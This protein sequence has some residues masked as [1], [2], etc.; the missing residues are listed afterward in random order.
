M[1]STDRPAEPL[2]SGAILA[3]WAEWADSTTFSWRMRGYPPIEVDSY[4][5]AIRDTFLGASQPPVRS[6]SVRGKEFPSTDDPGY[7]KKQVA[8]F[9]EAAGIRLAAIESTDRPAEP[10]VSGA[11]L[12]EWADSTRFSTRRLRE[13]YDKREV[14]VFRSAVRDTFLGAGDPL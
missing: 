14:D 9:L 13:G 5:D 12:A 11:I 3:G 6:A 1:E 7:D 10:P 2:V 8:A 4:L